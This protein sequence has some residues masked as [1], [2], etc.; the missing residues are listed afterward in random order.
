MSV[1]IETERKYYCSTPELLVEKLKI[2]KFKLVKSGTEIDEYFTDINSEYIKNRT[3]LRIRKSDVSQMEITFKGKSRDF[4]NTFSKLES[5]FKIDNNNYDNL[6]NLFSAIGY[7]SYTIVNKKRSTYKIEEESFTYSVMID[8]IDE[9]GGFVEFE[10]LSKTN[11][12]DE[13]MLKGKLNKFVELFSSINLEE[14]NLPYRD[15]V[16]QKMYNDVLPKKSIE[17]LHLNLDKF[18]KTYEK[19]F[20][21]YYKSLIEKELNSS[22]KWRAFK[23]NVYNPIINPDI[24]RKFDIYFES[25]KI[26]DSSFILL[27]QLLN[28][29]KDKN[30]K[31]ILST[32]CNS[33]FINSLL[34]KVFI[35][36]T[37]DKVIYLNNNKTI[38]AE[39]KK[40]DIDL[41]HYFNINGYDLKQTNSYLLVI[42]NNLLSL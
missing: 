42:I 27:F 9:L 31:I 8:T 34:N 30:I 10:I 36:S 23:D 22:I 1:R 12:Y 37:I 25:L 2:L 7:Y 24:E 38:Y 15:F 18:L 26:K 41:S 29:L 40:Y 6:I 19:E 20:Y 3:C 16:A 13:D 11:E 4:S 33:T 28:Q 39:L 32:N 17:G 5:N 35:T 14:A 21:K